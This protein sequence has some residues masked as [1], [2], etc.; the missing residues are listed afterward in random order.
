MCIHAAH[1]QLRCNIWWPVRPESVVH[2]CDKERNSEEQPKLHVDWKRDAKIEMCAAQQ[3]AAMHYNMYYI[4]D[5]II[6]FY[7]K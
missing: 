1:I 4:C 3:G 6:L 2:V 5:S 7:L